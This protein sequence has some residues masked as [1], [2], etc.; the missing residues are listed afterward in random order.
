MLA[1]PA[2]LCVRCCPAPCCLYTAYSGPLVEGPHLWALGVR[3][4]FATLCVVGSGVSVVR[5]EKSDLYGV[6][7][8]QRSASEDD[9]A[10]V[11][12][13]SIRVIRAERRV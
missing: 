10:R 8:V 12:C 4:F 2:L 9:S 13:V 7:D 3:R 5:R 11:E 6:L 1:C